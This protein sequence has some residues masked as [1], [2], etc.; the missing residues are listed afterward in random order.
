MNCFREVE[1]YHV[2]YLFGSST[3]FGRS[4]AHRQQANVWM[5]EIGSCMRWLHFKSDGWSDTSRSGKITRVK[6]RDMERNALKTNS[7]TF[8]WGAS[9]LEVASSFSLQ[10]IF[11][12]DFLAH[13]K[14]SN[15]FVVRKLGKIKCRLTFPRKTVPCNF[16][17]TTKL[18]SEEKTFQNLVKTSEETPQTGTSMR[19]TIAFN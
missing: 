9:I 10:N 4:A 2:S 18:C 1:T 16:K 19:F 17:V 5:R 15:E 3:L 13:Q 14:F 12:K 8:K 11:R 7:K 6:Y